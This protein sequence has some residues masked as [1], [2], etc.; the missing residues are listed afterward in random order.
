VSLLQSC[1]LI[2]I[3]LRKSSKAAL[4]CD[5]VQYIIS[6]SWLCRLAYNGFGVCVACSIYMAEHLSNDDLIRQLC[7]E[8]EL[9]TTAAR[10]K[11]D[12]SPPRI[13]LQLRVYYSPR[14]WSLETAQML[15]LTMYDI[16]HVLY[17]IKFLLTV[18]TRFYPKIQLILVRA[19][20]YRERN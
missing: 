16:L 9:T 6:L 17:S 3:L 5:A 19:Q 12:I 15:I 2:E 7:M 1:I 4:C 8:H 20:R 10:S 11:S 18:I 13:S 14:Y